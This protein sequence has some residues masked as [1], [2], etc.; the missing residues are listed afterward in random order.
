[1]THPLFRSRS[2]LSIRPK[3][4]RGVEGFLISG[5]PPNDTRKVSIFVRTREGA[6]RIVAA[7]KDTTLDPETLNRI[8]DR[9]L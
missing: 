2:T 9:N 7:Y 8:V 1:M 4:Y 5:K 3:V 6:D